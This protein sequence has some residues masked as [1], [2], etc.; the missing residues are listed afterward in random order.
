MSDVFVFAFGVFVTSLVATAV[1]FLFWGV[2]NE[3]D[4]MEVPDEAAAAHPMPHNAVPD[5]VTEPSNESIA[6][7]SAAV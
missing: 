2:S 6:D 5:S 7:P 1:A 3:P 4:T